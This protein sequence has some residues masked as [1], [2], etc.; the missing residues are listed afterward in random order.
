MKKVLIFIL[1]TGII[2]SCSDNSNTSNKH[3]ELV[4]LKKQQAELKEKILEIENQLAESDSSADLR[5][6][7]VGV[8]LMEPTVFNHFIE[9]QAKVEGD[10]DVI[11]SA[12]SM[13]T[14]T[15][16]NV[17]VGDKVSKG[18]VLAQTDDRVIRQGIEEMQAQ[19]DLSTQLYNKQK[20]L[21]DQKI[22]SEIQFLQAKANK[23]SMDKRMAG[24]QSQWDLTKIKSP[25]NGTVD[26]INLKVGQTVA[27]GLPAFRV[28]N[29]N[30]LKITA[31]VAESFISKVKKGN[32][33]VIYFPDQQKEIKSKL[34]YSGQAV[35]ALNRTFNVEVRLN[36]KDG[37]FNPNMVA[38]LK[39]VD[40]SSPQAFVVPVG[41]I[42]KSSDGEF[43]YVATQE[44]GKTYARRKTITSGLTY[45]GITEITKGI[46]DGDKVITFGY[47]N[48]IEG[49]MIRL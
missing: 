22:G 34:N 45:N 1:L 48:I 35:N 42:Q 16:I 24:L 47:Q 49:D 23:E 26:Q 39:I 18:Q 30:S 9:V 13:G 2:S 4:T 5:S 29:L 36:P 44:N 15:S 14:I 10:E 40:Y 21:W 31:E 33:V 38:V 37:N 20:N 46:S 6:K 43:V 19:L 32:D 25:I 8:S 28:V 41:S 12:E 11:V 7:N 3:A 17:K 27:P